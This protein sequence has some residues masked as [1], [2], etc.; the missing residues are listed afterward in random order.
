MGPI[1]PMSR[2]SP[3]TPMP[4]VSPALI[5]L[6]SLHPS[7]GMAHEFRGTLHLELFFP[8]I[9][10]DRDRSA[11]ERSSPLMKTLV[12]ATFACVS[13]MLL[14]GD[15][16]AQSA[17]LDVK[18]VTDV[19]AD[20]RMSEQVRRGTKTDT[21]A[22]ALRLDATVLTPSGAPFQANIEWYVFGR[23]TEEGKQ[24]GRTVSTFTLMQMS[25]EAV[26]AKPAPGSRTSFFAYGPGQVRDGAKSEGWIVRLVSADGK[27]LDARASATPYVA[28]AKDQARLAAFV[29]ARQKAGANGEVDIPLEVLAQIKAEAERNWPGNPEMQAFEIKN[30][31]DAH[32]AAYRK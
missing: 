26:T 31:T 27:L 28:L 21:N 11:S 30:K 1:C 16:H 20:I 32:K 3:M 17:R 19:T 4:F 25:K 18:V 13:G 6:L 24:A 14:G 10:L 22:P 2:I 15:L 9:R 29:A 12:L 23:V 8:E 5:R 7:H